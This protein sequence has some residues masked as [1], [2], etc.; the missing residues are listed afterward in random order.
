LKT[1]VHISVLISSWNN[2]ERL[3]VTLDAIARCAVPPG[4]DWEL[5]VVNNNSTDGTD[6]VI[7]G[8]AQK[9]PVV[10]VFEGRQGISAARNAGLK[11]ASGK[12]I[13]F[14]DDDVRPSRN[15]MTAYWDAFMRL[16]EKTFFGGPIESEFESGAPEAELLALAPYSVKGLDLGKE[17]HAVKREQM[18]IG[19]NWA[20]RRDILEQLG[21]FDLSKGFDPLSGISKIG[22]ETDLM[23]RLKDAGWTGVYV[24]EA[25]V[26]HFVPARKS[27]LEH[28][29]ERIEVSAYTD[30]DRLETRRG[31]PR[32]LG[33]PLEVYKRAVFSRAGYLFD[34][35]A[36]KKGYRNFIR[37][38]RSMGQLRGFLDHRK[39][40]AGPRF[41]AG[42]N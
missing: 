22:E 14:T 7:A 18:F 2:C 32:V 33:V 23:F 5:V 8:S 42:L 15:W 30:F 3:A 34:R 20:C 19:P 11:A 26:R 31:L 10:R 4:V 25:K 37:Y 35:L 29:A 41:Q 6:R 21:G 13:I 27:T 12:W 36:G 16:P 9:M 1:P 39:K 17:M 40:E 24:P 28:I 38:K